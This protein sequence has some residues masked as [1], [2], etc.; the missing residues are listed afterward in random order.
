MAIHWTFFFAQD[1]ELQSTMALSLYTLIEQ[2]I[3]LHCAK[4][5]WKLRAPDRHRRYAVAIAVWRL[6]GV[7]WQGSCAEGLLEL[8]V[9]KCPSPTSWRSIRRRVAECKSKGLNRSNQKK[10]SLKSLNK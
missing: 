8:S 4:P 1:R 6:L 10:E 2:I 7:N 3:A 9:R 5:Q